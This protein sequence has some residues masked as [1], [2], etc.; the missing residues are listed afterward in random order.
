M[1]DNPKTGMPWNANRWGGVE[2]EARYLLGWRYVGVVLHSYMPTPCV[3][4][5]KRQVLVK[6]PTGLSET[7]DYDRLRRRQ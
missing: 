6:R 7:F 5:A 2:V 3:T 1:A 4:G